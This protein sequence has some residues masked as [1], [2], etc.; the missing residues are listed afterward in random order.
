MAK[1]RKKRN[2]INETAKTAAVTERIANLGW[3]SKIVVE[4]DKI[5]GLV[6]GNENFMSDFS[7]GDEDD[8]TPFN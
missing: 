2:L 8:E 6:S 4:D 7:E 1:N 3:K 5:V